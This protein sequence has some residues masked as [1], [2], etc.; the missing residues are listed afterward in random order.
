M[1]G[2]YLIIERL[3]V[4]IAVVAAERGGSPFHARWVLGA[5][6]ASF[7]NGSLCSHMFRIA[8]GITI[9]Q[10]AVPDS[11]L[12]RG[13]MILGCDP[14]ELFRRSALIFCLIPLF[15]G[16]STVDQRKA[17]FSNLSPERVTESAWKNYLGGYRG[18]IHSVAY[19][20]GVAGVSFNE[21]EFET[22]GSV[23]PGVT[24]ASIRLELSG[25]PDNPLVYLEMNSSSSSEWVP[26]GSYDEKFTNIPQRE[27]G[28]KGRVLA[29]SHAPNQ[30]LISLQPEFFSPNRGAAMILTFRGKG[31]VDVEYIGHFGRRGN[32]SLS[33]VPTF[34]LYT[35]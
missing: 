16:C 18:V 4:N 22:D 3:L 8:H 20:S 19:A 32:G 29:Y 31:Y 35:Q 14:M 27:Y 15:F 7:I 34:S 33:R 23:M 24:V 13:R 2:D 10:H 26:S 5:R 1:H 12:Q 6:S 21:L 17:F 28:V 11:N 30:L 9:H 25:T